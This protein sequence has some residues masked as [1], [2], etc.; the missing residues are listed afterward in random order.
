MQH[1]LDPKN[2]IGAWLRNKRQKADLSQQDVAEMLS[3]PQMYVSRIETGKVSPTRDFVRRINQRLNLSRGERDELSAIFDLFEQEQRATTRAEDSWAVAQRAIQTLENTAT[4]TRG[5]DIFCVPGLLQTKEYVETLYA[6][7]RSRD[8]DK[9]IIER[10]KRQVVLKH[11]SHR[12]DFLMTENALMARI[13]SRNMHKRQ[14]EHLIAMDRKDN[15][16]LGIVPM[17]VVLPIL[18]MST[19]HIHDRSVV[20]VDTNLR[21]ITFRQHK[22]V[23]YFLKEFDCLRSVAL[24]GDDFS[25]FVTQLKERF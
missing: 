1:M 8:A 14:L 16:F 12:F 25:E 22:E 17:D 15:I 19:F 5:I 6:R 9:A 7:N 24:F 13:G 21:F 11:A 18:P 4:V 20:V 10:L 3:C 23:D 2:E